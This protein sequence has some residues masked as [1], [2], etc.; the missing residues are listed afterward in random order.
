MQKI[1]EYYP[2]S[3]F[4][5]PVVLIEGFLSYDGNLK[6]VPGDPHKGIDYVRKVDEKFISFDVFSSHDG[7]AFQGLSE[8]WGKFVVIRKKISKN[9][10]YDTIYA[11][12]KKIDETI[13]PLPRK[14]NKDMWPE[15]SPLKPKGNTIK[16]GVW[17]GVA[18]ATGNT[19]GIIQLHFELH[20]VDLKND[21]RE[22]IDPYGLNLRWSSGKYPQP[23]ESLKVLSHFWKNDLPDFA[24]NR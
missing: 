21:T 13:P 11:H 24:K 23:G 22:K 8:T 14:N 18:G 10:R 12:L 15:R 6:D 9:I 3:L 19:K 2:F 1:L 4:E 17:L 7:E 5:P 16:A 20:R